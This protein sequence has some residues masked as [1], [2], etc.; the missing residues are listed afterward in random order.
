MNAIE[1]RQLIERP[2]PIV[3]IASCGRYATGGRWKK[4]QFA[5]NFIPHPWT[6][7]ADMLPTLP[8]DP[9]D[10]VMIR[11]MIRGAYAQV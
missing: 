11:R 6:Y 5:A 4:L 3:R 1:R 9:E 2:F 8:E 7:T 10:D